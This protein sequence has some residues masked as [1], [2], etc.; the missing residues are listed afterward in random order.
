[1]RFLKFG[2]MLYDPVLD[3]SITLSL[4]RINVPDEV[5]SLM[6]STK[7]TGLHTMAGLEGCSHN[8][9]KILV[10]PNAEYQCNS[11]TTEKNA[12]RN[13]F[14]LFFYCLLQNIIAN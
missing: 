14:Y 13:R 12:V 7:P 5:C 2:V 9:T 3:F 1:M 11:S 6:F 4:S 10:V 8:D